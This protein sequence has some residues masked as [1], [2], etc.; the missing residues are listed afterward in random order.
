[1]GL[2]YVTVVTDP[3]TRF[4]SLARSSIRNSASIFCRHYLLKKMTWHTG[5]IIS[6]LYFYEYLFYCDENF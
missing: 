6:S 1:M 3:M 5:I 2:P 4:Q